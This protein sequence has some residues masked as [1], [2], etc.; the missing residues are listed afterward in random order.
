MTATRDWP[1]PKYLHPWI[2]VRPW[3][4]ALA[5]TLHIM[6]DVDSARWS[7]YACHSCTVTHISMQVLVPKSAHGHKMH[8]HSCSVWLRMTKMTFHT[9]YV[10]HVLSSCTWPPTFGLMFAASFFSLWVIVA[11]LAACDWTS[12]EDIF[13][14]CW[15]TS[16]AKWYCFMSVSGCC[17]KKH[18]LACSTSYFLFDTYFVCSS[19]PADAV[20]IIVSTNQ[21]HSVRYVL[22][23]IHSLFSC[24]S[25]CPVRFRYTNARRRLVPKMI[26]AENKRRAASGLPALKVETF[27]LSAATS[28]SGSSSSDENQDGTKRS[29]ATSPSTPSSKPGDMLTMS[30]MSQQLP[31]LPASAPDSSQASS[32]SIGAFNLRPLQLTDDSVLSSSASPVSSRKQLTSPVVSLRGELCYL[33]HNWGIALLKPGVTA[34]HIPAV[35]SFEPLSG[36][37]S[38]WMRGMEKAHER[39]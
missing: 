23:H 11:R 30:S 1:N 35:L 37:I 28:S 16:L 31:Q 26:D 12:R 39:C 7:S 8:K 21:P 36:F 38:K 25:F 14:F 9:C 24:V 5:L 19:V 34:L 18:S 13:K 33:Q 4:I 2:W 3:L 20:I 27:T 22:F 29:L 32:E 15:Q 17:V 10:C 6:W